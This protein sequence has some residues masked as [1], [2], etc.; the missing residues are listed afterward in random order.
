MLLESLR[1][2][3]MKKNTVYWIVVGLVLICGVF[4]TLYFG[5]QSG[6]V[7]KISFSEFSSQD[8]VADSILLHLREELKQ[9]PIVLLGVEPAVPEQMQVW[10]HLLKS[11]Q[12]A[13]LK[14][15]HIV[16]DQFLK[17][18]GLLVG[19][20]KTDTK[21]NLTQV[22]QVLTDLQAKGQ[23]VVLIVPTIYATQMVPGNVASILK[24]QAHL[25]I[26]SLSLAD[27]PR[28]REEEKAMRFPCSVG[29]ADPT[30]LGQLGCTIAQ[31]ARANYHHKKAPGSLV[32]LVD[33][34]GPKDYLIL[35]TNEH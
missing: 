32:G 11:N 23:R 31:E 19:A 28:S 22:I 3:S 29:D 33:Q 17:S 15:D 27:F 20:E 24:D 25:N 6:T 8:A 4:A 12:E 34:V 18:E 35:L 10:A 9:S 14:F 1:G 7:T 30:G 21:E 13:G 26:L 5:L 2:N 16:I